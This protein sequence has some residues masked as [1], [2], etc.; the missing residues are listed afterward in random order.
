MSDVTTRAEAGRMTPVCGSHNGPDSEAATMSKSDNQKVRFCGGFSVAR[1]P[2][3]SRA[4]RRRRRKTISATK[5]AMARSGAIQSNA[6]GRTSGFRK[7]PIS[8]KIDPVSDKGTSSLDGCMDLTR[9][10]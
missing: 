10:R 2:D 3:A 5:Q 6:S 9:K 7:R 8:R 4:F 1:K